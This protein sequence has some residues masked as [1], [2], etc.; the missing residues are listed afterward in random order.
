M[1]PI[2]SGRPLSIA[3]LAWTAILLPLQLQAA[4][5]RDHFA[6]VQQGKPAATIV[7]PAKAKQWITTAGDWLVEY[8]HKA[9][10]AK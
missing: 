4:D 3:I 6:I 7:L 9:T 2:L 5:S 8:V 10:G 1:H